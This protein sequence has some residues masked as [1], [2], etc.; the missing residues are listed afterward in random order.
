MVMCF[1]L[2][3][4]IEFY[5]CHDVRSTS[6]LLKALAHS[7]CLFIREHLKLAFTKLNLKTITEQMHRNCYAIRKFA[8][9]VLVE[10]V[11]VEPF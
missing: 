2:E 6:V 4:G 8:F 3:V 7:L 1:F 10:A 5:G 11:G 9:F